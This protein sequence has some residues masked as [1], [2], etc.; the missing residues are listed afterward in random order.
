MSNV[1]VLQLLVVVLIGLL[2]TGDLKGKAKDLME[3]WK[4]LRKR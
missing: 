3:A 2:L 4:E 1:G